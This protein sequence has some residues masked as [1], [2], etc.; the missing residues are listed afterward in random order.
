MHV[1]FKKRTAIQVDGFEMNGDFQYMC[2]AFRSEVTSRSM[3]GYKRGCPHQ[4]CLG[5][6]IFT[7]KRGEASVPIQG[8]LSEAWQCN[9]CREK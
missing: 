3:E 4:I 8:E 9:K 2:Q 6:A 7:M 5:L 1:E